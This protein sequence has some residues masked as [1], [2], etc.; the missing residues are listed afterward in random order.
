LPMLLE[1]DGAGKHVLMTSLSPSPRDA[2]YCLGG[3]TAEAN[4][5]PL[6]LLQLLPPERL[7][8]EIIILCTEN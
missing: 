4:Q 1:N 7:P 8:R 6:V 5:S 3:K 2:V